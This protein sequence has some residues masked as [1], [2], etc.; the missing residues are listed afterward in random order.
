MYSLLHNVKL[1]LLWINTDYKK[2]ISNVVKEQL[3]MRVEKGVM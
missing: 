1:F 3:K 2:Q